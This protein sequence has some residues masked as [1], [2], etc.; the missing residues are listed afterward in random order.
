MQLFWLKLIQLPPEQETRSSIYSAYN[1]GAIYIV[2]SRAWDFA[3]IIHCSTY[4]ITKGLQRLTNE[5]KIAIVSSEPHTVQF[6]T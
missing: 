3:C 5:R 4:C 2:L 1:F 6:L